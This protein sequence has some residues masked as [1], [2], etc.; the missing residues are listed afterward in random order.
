MHELSFAQQILDSVLSEAANYPGCKVVRVK[1]RASDAL[2][3]EPASLR[4]CLE[5]IS[6]G[7]IAEGLMLDMEETGFGLDCPVCGR[8]EVESLLDPVCPKCGGLGELATNTALVIEEI[9]LDE[10]DGET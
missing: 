8:V 1:L 2:A 9:E 5:A 3:L 6:V 7:T 10:H 4:F